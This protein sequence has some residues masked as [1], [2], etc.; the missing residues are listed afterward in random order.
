VFISAVTG[1]GTGNLTRECGSE[2]RVNVS[3]ICEPVVKL[4]KG[5][6][7]NLA[8]NSSVKLTADDEVRCRVW[9]E[10]GEVGDSGRIFLKTYMLG[11]N[12]LRDFCRA[13]IAGACSTN[14]GSLLFACMG[15]KSSGGRCVA[16]IAKWPCLS[17]LMFA[18]LCA[19]NDN[20]LQK[21]GGVAFLLNSLAHLMWLVRVEAILIPVFSVTLTSDA[22]I[23]LRIG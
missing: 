3:I 19:R 20:L 16:L 18:E 21:H 6:S 15:L 23:R 2:S 11:R 8:K 12:S 22:K 9:F 5:V 7:V 13:S 14:I 4:G 17:D 1:Q 10:K